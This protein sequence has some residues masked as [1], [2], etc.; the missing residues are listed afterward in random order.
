MPTGLYYGKEKTS[1]GNDHPASI[2]M[3]LKDERRGIQGAVQKMD[4]TYDAGES[5]YSF[6]MIFAPI[7]NMILS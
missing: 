6:N 7:D 5:V 1:E 4:I 3:D 2:E